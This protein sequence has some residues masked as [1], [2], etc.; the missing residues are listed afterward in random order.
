MRSEKAACR[1]PLHF[2]CKAE[3]FPCKAGKIPL[4]EGL[5]ALV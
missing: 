4:F 2:P 3:K 1:I 5:S